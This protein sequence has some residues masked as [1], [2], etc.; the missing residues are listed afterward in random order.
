ME[1]SIVFLDDHVPWLGALFFSLVVDPLQVL[2]HV[3]YLFFFIYIIHASLYH[4]SPPH[5]LYNVRINRA[6]REGGQTESRPE[7]IRRRGRDQRR[8]VR[9]RDSACSCKYPSLV[10]I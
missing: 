5:P 2:Y 6:Q 8:S 10:D 3:P 1:G 4:G 9:R 7:R